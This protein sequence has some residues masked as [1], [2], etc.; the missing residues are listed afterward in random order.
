MADLFSMFTAQNGDWDLLLEDGGTFR[1]GTGVNAT[2]AIAAI[3]LGNFELVA[4]GGTSLTVVTDDAN[5][6]PDDA[7]NQLFG[8]DGRTVE[9]CKLPGGTE[10]IVPNGGT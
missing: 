10:T 9:V 7:P 3:T 4:L 6:P 8:Y 5:V 1:V 2:L